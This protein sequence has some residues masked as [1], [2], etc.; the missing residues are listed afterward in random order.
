M[1][2]LFSAIWRPNRFVRP[3]VLMQGGMA[4]RIA[5]AMS[6]M[7][8]GGG[9]CPRELRSPERHLDTCGGK[10]QD[11]LRG[12]SGVPGLLA[13][14]VIAQ[15]QLYF[16]VDAECV[17][18]GVVGDVDAFGEGFGVVAGRPCRSRWRRGCGRSSWYW[19]H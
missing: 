6:A 11:V 10:S 18:L 19:Y 13:R 2:T 1:L 8:G 14:P 17:Y 4:G 16:L 12:G 3:L 9:F 15:Q 7:Q 5:R